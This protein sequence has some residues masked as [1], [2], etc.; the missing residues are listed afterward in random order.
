MG[1]ESLV[2]K[3]A[4]DGTTFA[5]VVTGNDTHFV[6]GSFTNDDFVNTLSFPEHFVAQD[7]STFTVLPGTEV[8]LANFGGGFE[9][10]WINIPGTGLTD[11]LI[12]PFGDFNLL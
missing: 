4:T 1:T 3:D 2:V 9:N 8:D 7:L 10:E 11:V 12:T 5:G 6:F